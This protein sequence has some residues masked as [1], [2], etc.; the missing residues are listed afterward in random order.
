MQVAL[1]AGSA[2]S[3]DAPSTKRTRDWLVIAQIA[4]TLMLLVATALVLKSFSRLQSLSLGYEPQHLFTGRFELP[5]RTFND[6]DKIDTSPARCST[7]CARSRN[8]ECRTQLERS[9]DGQLANRILARRHSAAPP[10]QMLNA[11]SRGRAR[12]LFRNAESAAPAAVAHSTTA[13]RK[14]GRASSLSD[15]NDGPTIFPNRTRSVR[16]IL[17]DAGVND[18]EG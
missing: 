13:I 2:G 7:K 15:T 5:W 9:A 8:R 17:W 16:G 4:L 11:R 3:G 12:R 18:A 1:K 10:S 6:R 14:T